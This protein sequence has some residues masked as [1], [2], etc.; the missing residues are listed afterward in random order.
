M[1]LDEIKQGAN[2][3]FDELICVEQKF[4][5]SQAEYL[6]RHIKAYMLESA[7]TKV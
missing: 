1:L 4:T 5:P 3:S 7:K 2:K 6:C